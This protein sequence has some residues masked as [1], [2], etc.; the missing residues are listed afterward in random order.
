MSYKRGEYPLKLGMRGIS[1]SNTAQ[2]NFGLGLFLDD[3]GISFE[4]E[5]KAIE[6]FRDNY[7]IVVIDEYNGVKEVPS[8]DT[9]SVAATG[10]PYAVSD[11]N[12]LPVTMSKDGNVRTHTTFDVVADA[13]VLITPTS[14]KKLRVTYL[15]Y[16]NGH[17]SDVWAGVRFTLTGNVK[18]KHYLVTQ[19]GNVNAN[20]IDNTLEGGVDEALVAY[21]SAAAA[22][23][24]AFNIAYMEV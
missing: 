18:H 1:L 13:Q 23:I 21:L 6:Y 2:G 11:T 4:V 5:V 7:E 17:T 19:G 14:G 24:V 16:S 10:I 8:P 9:R 15:S 12:P 22:G 20:L 3:K